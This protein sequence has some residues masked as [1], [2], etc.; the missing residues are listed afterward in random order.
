MK[1]FLSRP[2]APISVFISV[3]SASSYYSHCVADSIKTNS[4][5]WN[6]LLPLLS[7]I[8]NHEQP[9]NSLSNQYLLTKR[10]K[11]QALLQVDVKLPPLSVSSYP[12]VLTNK[13]KI[14]L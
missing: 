4:A 13:Q 8:N 11:E 10:T 2:I 7:L 12:L 3:T 14:E 6:H 9:S 5:T 1:S